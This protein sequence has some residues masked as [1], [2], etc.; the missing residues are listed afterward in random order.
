MDGVG[1]AESQEFNFHLAGVFAELGL[2]RDRDHGDAAG[3]PLA[4][5]D[6][7]ITL[8]RDFAGAGLKQ[9]NDGVDREERAFVGKGR[10]GG[11][12]LDMGWFLKTG[13]ELP[14]A[15]KAE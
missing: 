13:E 9:R 11:D 7:E 10:K 15:R 8:D 14:A 1:H 3:K 2:R 6:V 12:R 5:K 4:D